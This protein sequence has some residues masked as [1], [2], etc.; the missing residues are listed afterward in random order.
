M[1]HCSTSHC[2]PIPSHGYVIICTHQFGPTGWSL[3]FGRLFVHMS[4]IKLAC[5][6]RWRLAL[7]AHPSDVTH[8]L[9]IFVQLDIKARLVGGKTRAVLRQLD[10]LFLLQPETSCRLLRELLQVVHAADRSRRELLSIELF[11]QIRSCW[12]DYTLCRPMSRRQDLLVDS[13]RGQASIDV[14]ISVV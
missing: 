7:R 11:G 1:V 2:Y 8:L 9:D 5:D 13:F 12:Q 6:T 4:N 14:Y 10:E 3:Q